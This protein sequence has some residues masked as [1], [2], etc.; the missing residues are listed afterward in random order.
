MNNNTVNLI[1]A[2]NIQKN[3]SVKTLKDGSQVLVRI[4]EK[5]GS[6]AYKAS[7]AG[8]RVNLT[9]ENALH[10]GQVFKANIYKSAN[11]LKIV[12]QKEENQNSV[13]SIKTINQNINNNLTSLVSSSQLA[14]FISSLGL[15]PDNL[16]NIILLQMKNLGLK[17][18]TNL[19]NKIHDLA[20]KYKGKEKLAV[21]LIMSFLQ[22]GISFDTDEIE[23]ILLS[24][25]N[26]NLEE[27]DAELNNLIKNQNIENQNHQF[28]T[29]DIK[30]FFLSLLNESNAENNVGLLTISNHLLSKKDINGFGSW[31]FFPFNVTKNNIVTSSGIFRI[32]LSKEKKIIK[33]C[34]EH[35]NFVLHDDREEENSKDLFVLEFENNVCKRVLLHCD[36]E[37][38][39][40]ILLKD[41]KQRF[42]DAKINVSVMLEKK[43]K[44]LQNGFLDNEFVIIDGEF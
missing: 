17:Y 7:V 22:K 39:N 27:S 21:E 33:F 29:E 18:D 20:L 13:L 36:D 25:E 10:A 30:N 15:V 1:N 19:M 12:P 28:S 44:L 8:V 40:E 14:N 6:G 37:K 32:L 23:N 24:L 35:N 43:E 26:E 41:I 42:L 3:E 31:I 4:I 34:I 2:L 9:S 38:R 5:L 16:S 11:T